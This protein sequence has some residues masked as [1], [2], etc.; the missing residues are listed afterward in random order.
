MTQCNGISDLEIET[1]FKYYE[2]CWANIRHNELVRNSLFG[3]Y[4]AIYGAYLALIKSLTESLTSNVINIPALPFFVTLVITIIGLTFISMY[5]RIRAFVDRDLLVIQAITRLFN[6]TFKET[7]VFSVHSEFYK[8]R[9]HSYF[10]KITANTQLLLFSTSIMSSCLM[11]LGIKQSFNL[12]TYY[13]IL[14]FFLCF[15]THFLLANLLID[16]TN[17]AINMEKLKSLNETGN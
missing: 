13:L 16:A 2:V 17:N 6:E 1:I 5:I 8:K 3:F 12:T 14:L 9:S 4:I 7:K 15:L 10:Y 11:V